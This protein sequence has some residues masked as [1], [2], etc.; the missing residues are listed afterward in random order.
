MEPKKTAEYY[1]LEVP[2]SIFPSKNTVPTPIIFP[3]W[4]GKAKKDIFE[5]NIFEI[6]P[7]TDWE[8]SMISSMMI[9][10]KSIAPKSYEKQYL[11]KN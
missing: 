11:S 1:P 7:I 2:D 10:Y 8:H 4:D 9:Q 5:N 6:L 3:N